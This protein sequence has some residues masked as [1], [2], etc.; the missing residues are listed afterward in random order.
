MNHE[1]LTVAAVS[2]LLT[3]EVVEDLFKRSFPDEVDAYVT[4]M[5]HVRAHVPPGPFCSRDTGCRESAH[6]T[7]CDGTFS[8]NASR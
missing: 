1:P 4:D 5:G 3:N 2:A 6:R 8:T 7:A